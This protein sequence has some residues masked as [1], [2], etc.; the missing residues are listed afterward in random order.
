MAAYTGVS[1][2]DLYT[3]V[4]DY[5]TDYPNNTGRNY[6]RVSYADLKSGAIA[7]K[8]KTVSTVPLSSLVK[9]REIAEILK[10]W[11]SQ[12]KM[13]LGEPQFNIPRR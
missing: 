7:I 4:V 6:G 3:H 1:D 5:G 9:A 2:E 11:I 13:E 10:K 12:G 8:G